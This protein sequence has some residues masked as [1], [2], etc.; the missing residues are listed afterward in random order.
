MTNAI[1][2]RFV[3][4][5]KGLTSFYSP[6]PTTTLGY[7]ETNRLAKSLEITEKYLKILY[8]LF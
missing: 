4:Y 8:F 2:Y 3:Y 7:A 6:I 1:S 5:F